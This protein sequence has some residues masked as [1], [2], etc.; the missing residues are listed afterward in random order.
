MEISFHIVCTKSIPLAFF[1]NV[2][3]CLELSVRKP[4]M[5]TF[6]P[7]PSINKMVFFSSSNH[8]IWTDVCLVARL[9]SIL[10]QRFNDL[11]LVYSVFFSS[12]LLTPN[13][14]RQF[15]L[16]VQTALRSP[17]HSVLDCVS[18]CFDSIETQCVTKRIV[19]MYSVLQC[20]I[21]CESVG[22]GFYFNY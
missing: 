7:R 4:T 14:H 21:G 1:V 19:A 22:K 16:P 12:F 11:S 20:C 17:R 10:R 3:C 6:S 18:S 9:L 15:C 8:N 5:V 13:C 2:H